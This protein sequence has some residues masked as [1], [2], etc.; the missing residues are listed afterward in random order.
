MGSL[1]SLLRFKVSQNNKPTI[2]CVV[3]TSDKLAKWGMMSTVEPDSDLVR[4]YWCL[5]FFPGAVPFV[6][7]S[8]FIDVC[9]S[10]QAAFLLFCG[11]GLLMSAFLSRRRPFCSVVRVYWCL[12][13]FPGGVPFVLWSGFIDVCISFQAASLLFCG[14]W[15]WSCFM[16][17]NPRSDSRWR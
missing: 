9:I 7:W 5:H 12:H 13:F 14:R 2:I 8:G 4:G 16:M 3:Q 6:L 10:F 15:L 11:Q 1:D 17:M